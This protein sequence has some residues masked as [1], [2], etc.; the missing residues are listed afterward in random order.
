MGHLLR[1][2]AILLAAS[3]A[4]AVEMPLTVGDVTTGPQSHV[5]LRNTSSQPVTAWSLAATSRND[6][7]RVHREVYTV[8]GYLSEVTHGLPGSLEHRER[9]MPGQSR[10]VPLDPLPKGTTVEVIAAVLDD[11]TTVGDEDALAQIFAKRVRERDAL[12]AVVDGFSEVLPAK[13]GSDALSALQQRF[14]ALVQSNE[15]IPCR[16]ALDAVQQFQHTG[17][18]E[19][20]DQSLRTYA[21]F[22][23]REYELAKRHAVR[24]R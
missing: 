3:V 2:A 14:S 9:L 22:V 23:T 7:G 10:E 20:I 4:N 6:S 11:A 24:R 13:H 18:A 5:R 19:N 16:A 12:K 17:T 8:D 21:D 1:L 15:E